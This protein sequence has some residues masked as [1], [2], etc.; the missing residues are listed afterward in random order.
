MST[1]AAQTGATLLISLILLVALTMFVL[2]TMYTSNTNLR[3]VGNMQSQRQLEATGQK[4]IEDRITS[5]TYFDEVVENTGVWAGGKASIAIAENGYTVTLHRPKCIWTAP[6]EG[7]SALNPLAVEQTVW[8]VRATVTDPV[9]GGAADV[10]QGV[11]MRLL[12]DHCP[13]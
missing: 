2:A 4:T 5:L 12:A 1:R 7:T 8:S 9:T 3:V 10:T 11:R 13:V 6:E